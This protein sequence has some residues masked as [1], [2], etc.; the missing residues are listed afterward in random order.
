MPRAPPRPSPMHVLSDKRKE[1]LAN[2][3]RA[4]K[5]LEG[6]DDDVRWWITTGQYMKGY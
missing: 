3:S 4:L 6:N 5:I 2:P 1:A